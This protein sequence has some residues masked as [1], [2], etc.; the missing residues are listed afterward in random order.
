MMISRSQKI[1]LGIFITVSLAIL[2]IAIAVLSVDRFLQKRDIYYVAYHDI[3]IS[4]LDVGS[5]VKYLGIT[6]GSVQDIEI[7]PED[8]NRIIIKVGIKKGT[9]IRNDVRADISTIS[10][11]G[12][13]LIELRGGT[14]EAPLLKPGEFIQTGTSFADEISG[15]AEVIA[16]K[17]ELLLNNLLVIT[18]DNN[19]QRLNQLLEESAGTMAQ[20]NTMLSTN[21]TGIASSL[22]NIDSLT[23]YLAATSQSMQVTMAALENVATSDTL[24][25]TLRNI[26]KIVG[27]LTEADIYTLVERLNASAE[28][29]NQIMIEMDNLIRYNR[30]KINQTLDDLNETARALN[31]AARQIDENPAI[32]LGG[33]E[34]HNPPD[35]KLE[36]R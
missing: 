25:M 13:K 35:K 28:N 2:F 18:Q 21:K 20:L 4:G 5:A 17:I 12:I 31:N 7:D 10:I 36:K 33:S 19:R 30:S 14:N 23:H 34:P 6:V 32:L 27:K 29:A 9:P 11:T 22:K 24:L 15:K 1:R 8:I 16:D 3:S 26:T